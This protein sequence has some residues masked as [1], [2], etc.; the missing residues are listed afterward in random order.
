MSNPVVDYNTPEENSLAITPPTP[1]VRALANL[2]LLLATLWISSSLILLLAALFLVPNY[3]IFTILVIA[4][5]ASWCFGALIAAIA[6]CL[7]SNRALLL[8][9]LYLFLPSFW[10]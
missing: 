4:A 3:I 8:L 5:F 6:C 10:S 9:V 1:A 2:S 7:G